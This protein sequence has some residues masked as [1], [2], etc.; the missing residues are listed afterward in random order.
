MIEKDTSNTG[1]NVS[2]YRVGKP[3]GLLFSLPHCVHIHLDLMDEI[4]GTEIVPF[5]TRGDDTALIVVP[6][7]SPHPQ[8][9]RH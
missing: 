9:Q 6:P 4:K 5:S 8:T 7:S 1:I 3:C 2:W